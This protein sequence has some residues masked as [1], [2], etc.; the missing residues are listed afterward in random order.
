MTASRPRVSVPRSEVSAGEGR[1]PKVSVFVLT[2]NHADWIGVALDSILAQEAPFDFELLIAD[3]CSTDGTRDT[4][5]EYAARHPDL[6]RTH[7]PDGN[8]GVEGIWLEAARRCRGEYVAILEGDDYWTSSEKLARQVALLDARPG[9]SSCFHRATLFHDDAG[10]PPRPATPDFDS[11]VFELDDLIRSCFIPFLTVMFRREILA[12]VPEWVF[13]YAWFDWLFHI[14]CARRGSIGF[15]DEDMAAY[16]VHARGNWSSR[17][18]AAQLGEDLKVYERLALELPEHGELIERCVENRHCQLAVEASRVPAAMPVALLDPAGDMPLYFNGRGASSLQPAEAEGGI[19]DRMPALIDGPAERAAG[20]H[21]AA[22]HY[23]P[24]V[25]PRDPPPGR[26]CACLVPR[27]ADDAL[28]ADAALS[29]FLR[30]QGDPQWSDDWCR[31]WEV[32][33]DSALGARPTD[34]EPAEAM[35]ALVEI[36]GVTLA[37]P[38]P[39]ELHDGFLDEPRAGAVLDAKAIDVLGWAIGSAA[40]AV[41]VELSIGGELFWRAPLRAERPDLAEAFPERPEAVR[42]GF[43]TTMNLIGTPPEFELGVSVVFADQRRAAL[44]TIHGRHRWRRDRSPA[45]AELVSV[46]IPC[47]GQ[48]HY[49]SEAI[50]SV[51][52]QSYPHLEIVVVDDGSMDNASSVAS[53]YP[54][55]RCVREDNSGMAGARNVGIRSTNG[56]FLVFLDADDRLLPEAVEAGLRVLGQRPECAAAIGTYRRTSHDGKPLPTHEQPVVE[57][58]Q[59]GRLMRDNWAGF[60]ARAIYRRSLF[61]HVRTFDPTL[62]AAADFGFNLAVVREFPVCSHPALVAEHRE[63]GRNS[64]GD[65]GKMLVQTLAAMRQQRPHV[66]GDSDL[67]RDYREGRR[68]WRHYYGDLLAGQARRSLRERRFGDAL[69]EAALLARYR[70]GALPRLLRSDRSQPG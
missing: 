20:G 38:L 52:A 63:H 60:P 26:W 15:L 55:V 36:S 47:Y 23:P 57:E 46:V 2:Y 28:R 51:L 62:D 4:V 50:E 70:P 35:G 22:L 66:K 61:E 32:N 56:D 18:R 8:R 19:R 6:I 17:D 49:L 39:P 53:R 41:A 65:A 5:R 3:D 9:W 43:R 29:S 45:F 12:T 21:V 44:A 42:A 7:L 67:R 34:G 1:A 40:K 31:I 14:C 16:R 54:G 11:E 68:H 33:V 13:S 69:R 58:D 27:S 59:Y 37:E 10:S 25:P 64:S 24:R 48:A 30:Q